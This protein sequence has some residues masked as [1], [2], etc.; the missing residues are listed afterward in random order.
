MLCLGGSELYSC[1]VP[2]M[3]VSHQRISSKDKG[4]TTTLFET[5]WRSDPRT[6][7]D[8]LKQFSLIVDNWKFKRLQRDSAILVLILSFEATELGAVWLISGA[9]N[10]NIVQNHLNIALLNVFWYFNGRYRH[11]FIP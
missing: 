8:H 7:L 11:I 6:Y 5:K 3:N 4:L 10:E 1:W 9:P 2:V